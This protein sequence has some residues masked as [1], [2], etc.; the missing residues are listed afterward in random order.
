MASCSSVSSP[1]TPPE[2]TS[3]APYG[4]FK[5][6]RRMASHSSDD[7][8]YAS[9]AGSTTSSEF[10][11]K[12]PAAVP[13]SVTVKCFRDP[14]TV[15]C[16]GGDLGQPTKVAVR[17]SRSAR[18]DERRA[19][20]QQASKKKVPSAVVA[21]QQFPAPP[22]TLPEPSA[23][24]PLLAPCISGDLATPSDEPSSRRSTTD[25]FSEPE[26]TWRSTEE[27][28]EEKPDTGR[29]PAETGATFSQPQSPVNVAE[30]PDIRAS[31]GPS[32]ETVLPAFDEAEGATELGAPAS[33]GVAPA[34]EEDVPE[35]VQVQTASL[36]VG[37]SCVRRKV[38]TVYEEGRNAEKDDERRFWAEVDKAQL[39]Y[40]EG[41]EKMRQFCFEVVRLAAAQQG[42]HREVPE[43][44][45][46]DELL[47][48]GRKSLSI[49]VAA[50]VRA[51]PMQKVGTARG[52]GSCTFSDPISAAG[53]S[54]TLLLGGSDNNSATVT[55][56][57]NGDG[58]ARCSARE[59]RPSPGSSPLLAATLLAS[60]KT[61]SWMA[62]TPNPRPRTVSPPPSATT[63]TRAS[64]SLPRRT[65]PSTSE[66]QQAAVR[67]K[68][69]PMNL[70]RELQH[71]PGASVRSTASPVRARQCLLG[72]S[73]TGIP[74]RASMPLHKSPMQG[75]TEA[76]ATS[77]SLT[78]QVITTGTAGNRAFSSVTAPVGS[79]L[80]PS[81][82]LTKVAYPGTGPPPTSSS[83]RLGAG[84]VSPPSPVVT[85]QWEGGEKKKLLG[86]RSSWPSAPMIMGQASWTRNLQPCVPIEEADRSVT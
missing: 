70:S 80:A 36:G 41:Y 75:G 20:G 68:W 28:A 57:V 18:R 53:S 84:V 62:Q 19:S 29:V 42:M 12:S 22:A 31:L 5:L 45:V 58:S 61:S 77:V 1:P 64:P 23:S 4:S 85:A 51:Q 27:E 7:T 44:A 49:L 50:A 66:A 43:E 82:S 74:S 35:V 16:S 47:A 60:P 52:N 13:P 65:E 69:T 83:S 72:Q 32:S 26:E 71:S 8:A 33:S 34:E 38:S 6:R 11:P 54:T 86:D 2:A 59:R 3:V 79:R 63:G 67:P 9:G 76:H 81:G 73:W 17:Q 10:R 37:D 56:W 24:L 25:T 21:V 30:V 39:R 55:G 15:A 46:V 48:V 78:P 14:P 40:R